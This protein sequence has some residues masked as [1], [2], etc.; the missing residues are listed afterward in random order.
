MIPEK[1]CDSLSEDQVKFV[2]VSL[3]AVKASSVRG[4][5]G[6]TGGAATVTS[7]TSLLLILILTSRLHLLLLK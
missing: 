5:S 4:K 2:Y 1:K 3:F 7:T 6:L